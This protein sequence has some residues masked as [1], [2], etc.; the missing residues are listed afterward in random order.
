MTCRTYFLPHKSLKIR[1]NLSGFLQI[2][3]LIINQQ[4]T[5]NNLVPSVMYVRLLEILKKRQQPDLDSVCDWYARYLIA[6]VDCSSGLSPRTISIVPGYSCKSGGRVSDESTGLI[7][8]TEVHKDEVKAFI[9]LVKADDQAAL[10]VSGRWLP[11]NANERFINRGQARCWA[12]AHLRSHIVHC[13]STHGGSVREG[14]RGRASC[15]ED[16]RGNRACYVDAPRSSQHASTAW[17]EISTRLPLL[18][19]SDSRVS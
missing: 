2:S 4:G 5:D 9:T 7:K 18:H 11:H 16:S 12:R 19:A 10:C 14:V 3:A 13:A 6:Q 15:S 8:F 1:K 17:H